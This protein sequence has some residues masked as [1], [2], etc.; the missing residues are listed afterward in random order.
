MHSKNQSPPCD[1]TTDN[2]EI[3]Y[4]KKDEQKQKRVQNSKKN[5]N[6]K[7]DSDTSEFEKDNNKF[8]LDDGS[9]HGDGKNKKSKIKKT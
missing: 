9:K 2:E 8:R 3:K 6:T 4:L 1:D 5:L 7:Y